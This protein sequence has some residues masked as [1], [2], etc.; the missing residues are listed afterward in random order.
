MKKLL[1]NQKK[2]LDLFA[3]QLHSTDQSVNVSQ[4]FSSLVEE[5]HNVFVLLFPNKF[6]LKT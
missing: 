1:A 2:E 4:E 3:I 5:L 6:L